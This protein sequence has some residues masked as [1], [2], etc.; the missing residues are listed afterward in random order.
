MARDGTNGL[1]P[2]VAPE[3]RQP[4][5]PHL[6][7]L[8]ATTST[9]HD[10]ATHMSKK[11]RKRRETTRRQK[12]QRQANLATAGENAGE[13]FQEAGDAEPEDEASQIKRRADQ[14]RDYEKRKREKARGGQSPAYLW[15]GGIA[16]VIAVAVI[17]GYLLLSGGGGD[18]DSTPAPSATPDPRIAGLPIDR[19]ITVEADDD[20]NDLSTQRYIPNSITGEAGEVIEILVTNIGSVAHNLTFPGLDNE[21]NTPD[22]WL[23][24]PGTIQPGETGRVVVKFDDPGAYP[25]KCDFHPTQTGTLTLS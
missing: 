14:K 11:D 15:G 20:G 19:T 24:E 7:R 3:R 8:I 12:E 6:R 17:G 16:A 25:F 5:S 21:Y 22:D 4:P 9:R 10:V 18:N 2:L 13:D 23:T 1:I